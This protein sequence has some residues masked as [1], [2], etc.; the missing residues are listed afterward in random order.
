[1]SPN[2]VIGLLAALWLA[3]A[4]AALLYAQRR[5]ARARLVEEAVGRLQAL[6]SVS[7]AAYMIVAKAGQVTAS[8]ALLSMLGLKRGL[9]TLAD[10]T[11]ATERFNATD[12]ESLVSHIQNMQMSGRPFQ[13]LVRPSKA[14]EGR[15]IRIQAISAPIALAGMGG[16]VVWWQDLTETQSELDSLHNRV[17][18]LGRSMNALAALVDAAPF[19]VWHRNEA[20]DLALVN[21][22]YAQAVELS[23][24]QD[25]VLSGVELFG[26]GAVAHPR[27][28][29][30]S[31]QAKGQALSRTVPAIIS[32]QRRMFKQLDVP[33]GELGIAGFALDVDELEQ[34]RAELLRFSQAQRETLDRLSAGVALFA[35]DRTLA[36]FNHPFAHS[37]ELDPD[38]LAD[39]PEFDHVLERMREQRRLPEERDFPR[40]RNERREW[41][42]AMVDAIDETWAL[43]D[44]MHLR[45][46]AQPHPDGG[47]LLIFEDRTEQFRLASSR[48]TLLR[49]QA[50]TLDNLFEAVCVFA[51][52]GRL[53]LWNTRFTEM[54]GVTKSELQ[55]NPAIDQLIPLA[56]KALAQPGRAEK[57]RDFVRAATIGRSYRS[58]RL[59]LR[60]GRHLEFAAVPLPDGNA[61]FTMLDISDRRRIEAALRDRNE[62][63]EA[64]DR[65][66]STFVANM[67]YE[68]RT[69]LTSI[70]GFSE[71]LTAGYVGALNSQQSDY[72]TAILEAAVRLQG[73]IDNILELT[74]SDAG[75][76][77][78]EIEKIDLVELVDEVLAGKADVAAAR[79]L[80][81]TVEMS[82]ALGS[83]RGDRKRLE[84]TLS[85]LLANSI[86]FTPVGGRVMVRVEGDVDEVRLMVIDNGIGIAADQQDRIFSPFTQIDEEGGAAIGG[87]GLALVHRYVSLHGGRVDLQS[88]PGE[89]TTV[90]VILPR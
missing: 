63:L 41:F 73:L 15:I 8:D 25:V 3:V 34:T 80:A 36:F 55:A 27:A 68:L 9:H 51:A 33:L 11:K 79:R 89:G 23:S 54:W 31:A 28:L 14:N 47:L 86:S 26:E 7:P 59:A 48:D 43:P 66:K 72:I 52:N 82:E 83:L 1:M 85:H 87:M 22:A 57:L 40:W 19:P 88:V 24:S 46:L 77:E 90:T 38:W 10:L 44:G 17:Q 20:G 12:I 81:L 65:L 49:V 32:G 84:A 21:K 18:G 35:A 6:L 5:V 60:D 61:L 13:Q 39:G 30:L 4:V 70:L 37:F 75:G 53:Q 45:V 78:L 64:A 69:P 42:T 62:A 76:L 71:M 29:A 16:V 58:G 74:M 67:S 50:A 56:A 2:I